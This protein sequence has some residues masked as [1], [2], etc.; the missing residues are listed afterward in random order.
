MSNTIAIYDKDIN[1]A[2]AMGEATKYWKSIEL[3]EQCAVD[4]GRVIHEH[5]NYFSDRSGKTDYDKALVDLLVDYSP[6][7]I[8]AVVATYIYDS[9]GEHAYEDIY[10]YAS[11]VLA[12]FPKSIYYRLVSLNI[13]VHHTK[14]LEFAKT[15]FSVCNKADEPLRADDSETKSEVEMDVETGIISINRTIDGVPR[16]IELTESE[17]ND[18]INF[19]ASKDA[20]IYPT[21]LESE[22]VN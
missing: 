10:E 22:P 21:K 9:C 2:K 17:I 20:T 18:I 4:I 15:V 8:E 12:R 7:R 6:D 5:T 13:P 16:A 14:V 1:Y 3:N 19:S 11:R